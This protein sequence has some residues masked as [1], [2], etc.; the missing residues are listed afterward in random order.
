MKTVEIDI[1]HTASPKA[2]TEE[3]RAHNLQKGDRLHLTSSKAIDNEFISVAIAIV[4]LIAIH[5][6]FKKKRLAFADSL[7]NKILTEKDVR[8]IEKEIRKEYAI[9]LAMDFK[10]DSERLLWNQ[11]SKSKLANEYD[12]EPEYDISMVKQPNPLYKK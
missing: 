11:L 6:L 2:L 7:L 3:M 1:D 9:E 4:V 8:D 5:E 10:E 12:F